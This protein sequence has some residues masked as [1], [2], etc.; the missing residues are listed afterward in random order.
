MRRFRLFQ[1]EAT[2]FGMPSSYRGRPNDQNV[3]S[4]PDEH[5]VQEQA[6]IGRKQADVLQ[7]AEIGEDLVRGQCQSVDGHHTVVGRDPPVARRLPGQT[8][9]DLADERHVAF[10]RR[11]QPRASVVGTIVNRGRS[12]GA[13]DMRS[14]GGVVGVHAAFHRAP[15]RPAAAEGTLHVRSKLAAVQVVGAVDRVIQFLRRCR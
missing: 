9:A 10:V 4:A 1:G 3:H 12:R 13:V 11:D 6:S 5:A 7:A 15:C 14:R 8:G 2:L